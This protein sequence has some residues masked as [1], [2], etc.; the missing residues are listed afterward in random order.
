MDT[1]PRGMRSRLKCGLQQQKL[2]DTYEIHPRKDHRGVDL[3]SNLLSYGR[4]WYFE[5]NAVDHAISYA[6][7]RSRSHAAVIHVY[8]EVGNAIETHEDKGEFKEP[9]AIKVFAATKISRPSESHRCY[10]IIGHGDTPQKYLC[11]PVR[12]APGQKGTHQCS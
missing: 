8:D 6:K 5:P 12:L 11:N 2:V 9:G 7:H 10:E 4:R 3:M 1:S